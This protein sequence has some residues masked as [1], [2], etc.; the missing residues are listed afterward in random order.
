MYSVYL[1]ISYIKEVFFE[2]SLQ[3]FHAL[4][5]YPLEFEAITAGYFSSDSLLHGLLLPPQFETEIKSLLNCLG[6][7]YFQYFFQLFQ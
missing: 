6:S 4:S 5:A 7:S 3:L 1:F 2:N